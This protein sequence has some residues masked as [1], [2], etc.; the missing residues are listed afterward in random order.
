MVGSTVAHYRVVAKLGSG[1]MGEVYRATDTRLGRDVALKLLP[2]AAASDASARDRLIAEARH[3]SALNHPHICHIYEVNEA[4]GVIYLAMELVEGEPLARRIP[5]GGLLA[6]TVMRYGAQVA[7]AMDHAHQRRILHRDL[8]SSN[9]MVTQSGAA[10]VLDFGLAQRIRDDELHEITQSRL[11][12]LPPGVIAGTLSYLA[13]EV[14]SGQPASERSDIWA[15]GVLLY[16]MLSGRLPFE[17]RTG[18]EV[19]SAILRQEPPAL[20]RVPPA[21]RAVIHR[22]LAKEPE[23]RYGSAAEVRAA[24][25]AI[26]SAAAAG[27]P[28]PAGGRSWWVWVGLAIAA[29]SSVLVIRWPWGKSAE[30]SPPV[31]DVKRDG[32]LGTAFLISRPSTVPEANELLQRA[33]MFTRFQY[34]P[35]RARPMLERALQLDPGFTEA[36]TNYALTFIIAVEGGLSNDPGDIFRAEEE[37]RRTLKEDP[38]SSRAH[39]LMGAVHFYQGRLDLARE[40]AAQAMQLSPREVGGRV[41]RMII[42]RFEGNERD[43]FLAAHELIA[44]EPLFWPPRGQLAEM[45][46]EQG[47]T[48]EAI[49][50]LTKILEQDAQNVTAYR[51]LARTHLDAGDLLRAQQA[52]ERVLP[53]ARGNFR[54]RLLRAQLHAVEGKRALALKEM[55][56]QL[57]K[58]SDVEPFAALNAAEVYAVL[59][60]K[61]KAIEWLDRSMRKGDGRVDWLRRDP[62]LANVRDHPRFQQILATMEFRRQKQPR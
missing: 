54:I 50:E 16:E 6:E 31:A 62:L 28:E 52:L 25:E 58:Y 37:L 57:L 17:G 33:M 30:P 13:P 36:R 32:P 42:G 34:D 59:G 11:S 19:S 39:A 8:K 46:R 15:L 4:D 56:G 38:R 45:F 48:A 18:F 10:K 22:C 61:E 43:A 27:R 24:L 23:Q 7:D 3:A 20:D 51:G 26:G 35:L 44:M 2:R 40:E 55:D 12:G 14:L 5:E 1:G 47:K 49:G 60:D 29:T 41:W 21:L 53:E 9:V